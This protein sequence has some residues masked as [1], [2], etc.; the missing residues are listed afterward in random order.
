MPDE[1]QPPAG[2]SLDDFQTLLNRVQSGQVL[3]CGGHAWPGPFS[4]NSPVIKLTCGQK[5]VRPVLWEW[6][7]GEKPS[8]PLHSLHEPPC[9]EHLTLDR[10]AAG[11]TWGPPG[12]QTSTPPWAP[13][14]TPE[15]P[16]AERPE[17]VEATAGQGDA[18]VH[19]QVHEVQSD[20]AVGVNFD[21][22]LTRAVEPVNVGEP[23]DAPVGGGSGGSAGSR[24]VGWCL[25]ERRRRRWGRRQTVFVLAVVLVGLLHPS[26]CGVVGRLG[27]PGV[28]VVPREER[29]TTTAASTTGSTLAPPEST[30][31]TVATTTT[32][33]RPCVPGDCAV[34][35]D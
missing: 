13:P 12:E 7:H 6:M 8:K 11:Q 5:S 3:P 20:S 30:T 22:A 28:E 16:P 35:D 34:L 25:V 4:K 24:R 27:R 15:P 14:E 19:S 9:C 2:L 21:E 10:K 17:P 1:I 23:Q 18:V 29:T 26:A 32:E 33:R 31:T